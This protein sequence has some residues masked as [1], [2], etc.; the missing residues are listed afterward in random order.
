[1][2]SIPFYFILIAYFLYLA[3]FFLF[4]IANV[5]HIYSTGTFTFPAIA[6]TSIVS[7]I[8][9]AILFLTFTNLVGINWS[10]TV[11]FFGPGGIISFQ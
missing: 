1:M 9:V 10:A 4:S 6:V 8:C 5:Y 2:F 3:I 7:A 11:E